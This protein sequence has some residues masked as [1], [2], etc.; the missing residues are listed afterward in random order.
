MWV[1]MPLD[2]TYYEHEL[3]LYLG[4]DYKQSDEDLK[5]QMRIAYANRR[6]SKVIYLWWFLNLHYAYVRLWLWLV[7]FLL[8]LGGFGV[9]WLVDLFRI[10]TILETYNKN[11]AR[12]LWFKLSGECEDDGSEG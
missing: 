5:D 11:L 2:F 10:P 4:D 12:G 1:A 7:A 8:T 9:W 3:L 6:K